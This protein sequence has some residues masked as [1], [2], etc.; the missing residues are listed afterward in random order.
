MKNKLLTKCVLAACALVGLG[1][2]QAQDYQLT[3]PDGQLTIGIHTDGTLQ[4]S[5][6]H[7]GTQVLLPSA[8][9]LKGVEKSSSGKAISFGPDVKVRK[10]T[11]QSVNT[12]FAT[13]FYKKAEVKDE[14][15]A[16]TLKC[17]GGFSVEFRAYDDGA[18]YRLVSELRK[19]YYVMAET[20]DFN[21]AQPGRAFIPY[22][23]ENRN[24][25]RYCFSLE[26]Y[27]DEVPLSQMHADSLAITPLLV[28]VADGKKA[29]VMDGGVENYPGMFLTFN[30]ET[31]QGVQAAFAPVPTETF[32][33]GHN[34][35]NLIPSERADYIASIDGPRTLPW[36]AVLV[37]TQDTQLA[38]N[39]MAQRL[40]P[41]CRIDDTSWIKPGKVAW[42]WWN[43]CNLSGVDF[44]AGMNTPT[45]KAYIDFAAQ[46][47]L[48]YIIIDDGWSTTESLT[49]NLNPDINL[50]E[51]IAYGN[52][53]GVGIILWAAWRNAARN[54]EADFAHYEKLGIKGFKI[55]FF[56][57]DDQ[58]AMQSIE[59][60]AACAA[61]HHLLL[62]LHGMKPFGLQR[63]Y[64]NLVN[65]EGVKGLENCK[66]E[67]TVNGVPMHDFPR[68][69]VTIP[70]LRQLAGPMDYTP[71]A[72]MNA[73]R[74]NFRGIND[75][76]MSQGTRVHQMAMYTIFEAPLQMLSDSPSKYAKEPEYTDFIA[77]VPT[78]FD[79]TVALAGEV[80]EYIILARRK[81]NTWFVAA[82]TNWTPRDLTIDLS[83]L[84][85]GAHEA[86][87]FSDG[88]NA[89]R[90]ATDWRMETRRLSASDKLN[91]HLA[92]G[93]GWTARITVE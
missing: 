43:A 71:G 14:Y 25:E 23:N 92:P 48:E 42:D 35:F 70:Y 12:S 85:A 22:V 66:W 57:R 93:G 62:D 40:A 9:A 2:A 8:I 88:V 77:Q 58:P 29:T 39:D 83:F 54:T 67:P 68:Y 80:G 81:G 3:S 4:W 52:Q 1:S 18:A 15:N 50:P 34:R 31:R 65:F 53:K 10:A 59:Q 5:I 37:T 79:E 21:F 78:T 69:D 7:D 74:W 24:G 26:S 61:R 49:E 33:G 60:I 72:T 55:D 46:H 28:E 17:R 86:V 89:D 6:Q 36:R 19:P 76:P 20:A 84:P 44:K 75:Q 56:D 32:I 11:R 13:P 64:P 45:Y 73:N 27:Y 51:L 41:A 16:L 47:K 38:D 90:D 91:V 63:A 82:M 30:E 87:I